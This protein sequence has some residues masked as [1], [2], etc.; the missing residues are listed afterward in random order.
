LKINRLQGL[1]YYVEIYKN[2][3]TN[4]EYEAFDELNDAAW[5]FSE[6]GEDHEIWP[7]FITAEELRQKALETKEELKNQNPLMP[8]V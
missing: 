2:V 1:F 3:H 7:G 4:T 8:S 5:R 6:F